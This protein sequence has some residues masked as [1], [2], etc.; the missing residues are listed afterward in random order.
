MNIIRQAIIGWEWAQATWSPWTSKRTQIKSDGIPLLRWSLLRELSMT[1]S[2]RLKT[3]QSP[4]RCQLWTTPAR[5][6]W[7]RLWIRPWT[8]IIALCASSLLVHLLNSRKIATTWTS[9]SGLHL[10]PLTWTI[11]MSLR[12]KNSTSRRY[13]PTQMF[14][15]QMI[16]N[17]NTKSILTRHLKINLIGVN[18]IPVILKKIILQNWFCLLL[19]EITEGYRIKNSQKIDQ[20]DQDSWLLGRIIQSQVSKMSLCMEK[21][22]T[23]REIWSKTWVKFRINMLLFNVFLLA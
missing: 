10:C 3:G 7:T 2:L 8:Q 23:K 18:W 1:T 6:T 22:V 12:S 17:V 19:E 14:N 9:L 4:Q 5:V 11:G 15:S 16:S 13:L 21:R 20:W